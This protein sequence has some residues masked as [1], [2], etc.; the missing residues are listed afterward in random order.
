VIVLA[1]IGWLLLCLGAFS[2]IIDGLLNLG[3]CG[4]RYEEKYRGQNYL[5]ILIGIVLAI[6]AFNNLPF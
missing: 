6:V 3:G 2:F 4:D 1:W 5:S